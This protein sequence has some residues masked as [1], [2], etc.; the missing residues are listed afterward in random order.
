MQDLNNLEERDL[1]TI[2][3]LAKLLGCSTD[4]IRALEKRGRLPQ[5]CEPEL[6]E[7]TGTRYWTRDQAERLKEWNDERTTGGPASQEAAEG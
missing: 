5:G 1:F 7:I 6:D 3:R 4:T 2:G